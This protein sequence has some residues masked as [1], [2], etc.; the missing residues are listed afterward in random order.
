MT[1]SL[2]KEVSDANFDRQVLQALGPVLVYYWNNSCGYLP[3][4]EQMAE[5]YL[6]RLTIVTLNVDDHCVTPARYG[7]H[8]VPTLMLFKDHRRHL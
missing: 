7:V 8:E 1:R 4:L 3:Y 2:I 5:D 6:G